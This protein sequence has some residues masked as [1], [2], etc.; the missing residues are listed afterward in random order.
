VSEPIRIV[1]AHF[2]DPSVVSYEGYVRAGGYEGLRRALQLAPEEVI[3]EVKASGLRGRGGAGFPTGLKWSFVP[4]D[5]GKPTYVVANFDESEPGT[6]GNREL[7]ERE[8][9]QLL[10]G[11]AIAAYAI[12]SHLAFI[13]CRGE[14][15]WPG[16]VLQRALAEAYEHGVLG[17]RVLGSDYRLDVV[18]HRGAGAYICGEET[19]LLSSSRASAVSRASGRRSPRSRACTRARPSSTTWRRSASCPTS[20]ATGRRGSRRSARAFPRARRCS[21]SPARSSARATTSCRWARRSG[22]CSRS[23]PAGCSA[24]GR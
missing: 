11:I 23:T 19:A 17:E 1:T 13:Y 22:S 7:V 20:S 10:E 21:R 15:L 8:P 5:T 14:F 2:D 12:R 16:S 3:A 24:G 9:H 18:L 4:Q 6:F